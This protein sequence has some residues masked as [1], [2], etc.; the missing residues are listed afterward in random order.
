MMQFKIG[1]NVTWNSSGA[2]YTRS[3]IGVVVEVVPRLTKPM[4]KV[5]DMGL[6]RD[7]ESYIVKGWKT[8]DRKRTTF[9]WPLVK[10]L[11]VFHEVFNEQALRDEIVRVWGP[12]G[13]HIDVYD[14]LLK[15]AKLFDPPKTVE[16]MEDRKT[17]DLLVKATP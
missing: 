16:E 15:K 7:H 14:M 6:W 9:Y 3:K 1:D 5:K 2:G 8:T 11:R 13:A 10:N 4:T 12:A 17:I